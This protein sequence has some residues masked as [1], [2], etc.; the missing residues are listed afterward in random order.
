MSRPGEIHG[1]VCANVVV[2]LTLYARQR[3]RGY[4]CSNDTGIIW[5]RRPDTVKGPDIIFF[6]ESRP[7]QEMEV[8]YAQRPPRLAVE[9]RS[10]N[11]RWTKVQRRISQFLN[12]GTVLV[13]LVDPEERA[14]TVYRPSQLPLV[15]DEDEE[16]IGG[17]EL[18]D[19]RCPVAA[20]FAM[21][22]A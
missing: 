20:F 11:D 4:A 7:V 2:A 22:G 13:W 9:V 19:F 17:D 3:K 18:P 15:L 10:P 12:W 21:P 8:K 14:V 16:L 6:D 5:Q 1:F